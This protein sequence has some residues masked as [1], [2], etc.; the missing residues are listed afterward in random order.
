[1]VMLG[2]V[3]L[4]HLGGIGGGIYSVLSTEYLD[5]KREYEQNQRN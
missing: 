3:R 4:S 2:Q 5:K 1:M